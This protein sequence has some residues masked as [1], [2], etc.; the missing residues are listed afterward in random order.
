MWD[1][2]NGAASSP[3]WAPL[4]S[5]IVRP[6]PEGVKILLDFERCIRPLA[7][8]RIEREGELDAGHRVSAWPLADRRIPR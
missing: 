5:E 2:G 7:G 6:R 8:M 4:I 1:T 3:L